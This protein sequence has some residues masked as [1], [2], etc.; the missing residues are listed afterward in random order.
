MKV[1]VIG[2]GYVGI[3]VAARFAE[4]GFDVVGIDL[5]KEKIE[6]INRGVFP[7]VGE[8]PG[9]KELVE[10]VVKSESLYIRLRELLKETTP[11]G[12]E[13]LAVST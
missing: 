4:A 11:R 12:I 13:S 7:L 6:K 3:P 5:N 9:M 1:C 8:E 10:R 2:L